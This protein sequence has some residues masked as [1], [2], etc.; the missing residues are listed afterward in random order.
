M[1]KVFSD[2]KASFSLNLTPQAKA[3]LARKP[4]IPS[5]GLV[6]G[7][8]PSNKMGRLIA[9]ESQ[10]EQKACYLF[11][12]SDAVVSFR[13]QPISIT[14]EFEGRACRYT[15]D[16]EVV[17][18]S[19]AVCFVEVKPARFLRNPDF[20][21]RFKAI[22]DQLKNEGYE[23]GFLTDEEL[24]NGPLISN[25]KLLRPYLR[26]DVPDTCIADAN[27]LLI[28]QGSVTYSQLLASLKSPAHTLALIAQGYLSIDI[29][30]PIEP[31]SA[32]TISTYKEKDDETCLFSLR[33]ILDHQ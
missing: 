26:Y 8:F 7:G 24:E 18:R 1:R 29:T 14:Y 5:R 15:P 33:T 20:C 21:L 23:F 22:W 10:L 13:E 19:G 9:W 25:L 32:L 11:E 31:E 12:F 30:K 2:G 16:F 4:V 28:D 17:Y 6:R 27:E 3:E